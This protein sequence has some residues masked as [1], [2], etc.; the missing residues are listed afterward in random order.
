MVLSPDDCI[1][2]RLKMFTWEE[3]GDPRGLPLHASPRRAV[4]QNFSFFTVP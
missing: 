2:C 1:A 3:R 4:G